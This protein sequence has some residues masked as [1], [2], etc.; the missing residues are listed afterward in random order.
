MRTGR[1]DDP[2]R[3]LAW[4][5]FRGPTGVG[6]TEITKALA[7]YLFGGAGEREAEERLLR[8]DMNE[9]GDPGAAARLVGT[10][11][12]QSGLLQGG[13]ARCLVGNSSPHARSGRG[14]SPA[15]PGWRGTLRRLPR[16]RLQLL[17]KEGPT[18]CFLS[19]L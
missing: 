5:L 18:V 15:A 6:K 16:G 13:V 2:L 10:Y 4:F 3:R 1:V 11:R 14:G 8:F 7:A 9:L 17:W 19:I 12:E